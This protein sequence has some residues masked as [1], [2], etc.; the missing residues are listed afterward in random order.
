MFTQF[1]VLNRYENF[2]KYFLSLF[3]AVF[4]MPLFAA[5]EFRVATVDITK[6]LNESKES[7]SKR[8]ELDALRAKA[9]AKVET[10]KK[11]VQA[12]EDKLKA[13]PKIDDNSKEM[14]AY[15]NQARDFNRLVKDTEEDLKA[16]YLKVN[17]MLTDK[18]VGVIVDYAK[19]HNIDL[20]LDKSEAARGPVLYGNPETDITNSVIASLNG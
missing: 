17:K 2:M 4:C 18:A 13:N 6:V 15:R 11:E 8:Q 10:K 3:V 19:D 9:Q 1:K 12:V 20:V 16:Q 7:Q 14:D 5:A